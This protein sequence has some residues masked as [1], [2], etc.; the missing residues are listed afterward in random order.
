M[1]GM[2]PEIEEALPGLEAAG[3]VPPPAAPTL[4][5]LARGALLPVRGDLR[6]LLYGGV[7]LAI[8]GVGELV[9]T[10]LAATAPILV[11]GLIAL[12]AVACLVWAHGRAPRFTWGAGAS[13][14]MAFDYVLLLGAGLFAAELLFVE[15]RFSALGAMWPTHFLVVAVVYATLALRYDSKLLFS[16]ALSSFAAWRGVALDSFG[17]NMWVHNTGDTVRFNAL[18]CAVLFVVLGRFMAAK[19]R[20]AHFEP[21]ATYVGWILA[22]GA[23]FGGTV[24]Y[25]GEGIDERTWALALCAT[26]ALLAWRAVRARRFPLFALAVFAAWLGGN[27][28]VSMTVIRNSFT[29]IFGWWLVSG[30]VLIVVLVNAR[31]LFRED[32]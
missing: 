5:R 25:H 28:F 4:L 11:A 31:R 6:A 16:L 13:T 24:T 17:S 18:G 2:N 1:S 10:S 8:A 19:G 23:M 3:L 9:R 15:Y 7:L 26:G 29:T 30:V 22:L 20:K 27:A 12:A 32:A 21:T 14:H